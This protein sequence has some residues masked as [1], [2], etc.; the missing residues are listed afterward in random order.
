MPDGGTLT[1]E[2]ANIELREADAASHPGVL[3]GRYVRLRV[4]DTGVG[5]D[6][7]TQKRIFEPF[8]TTKEVGRGTG[9]G[10][11]TVYGI[12]Q[13]CGG[14][15]ELESEPGRGTTF[16][17]YLPLAETSAAE[18]PQRQFPS[19][20]PAGAGTVLVVEDDDEVRAVT[21]RIL[22][23]FGYTVLD[24]G[25]PADAAALATAQHGG[26]DLLLAD[27]VMPGMN[28]PSLATELSALVPG[29]RVILMSGY[30]GG[31]GE[32]ELTLE[33]GMRYI[34]KPFTP[35]ALTRLVADLLNEGVTA[36]R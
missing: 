33:S 18:A 25:R 14:Q 5:I 36:S 3:S 8:F 11:S 34:E 26:I 17:I 7:A 21:V 4:R 9:L 35:A 27:V 12:V 29:L 13:Q 2:T 24:T 28:G 10:L 1:L 22:R 23:D 30:A 31:H 20:P 16:T 6:A 15:I 32:G 19:R